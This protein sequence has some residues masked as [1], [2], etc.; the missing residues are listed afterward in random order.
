[1]SVHVPNLWLVH[2]YT[3]SHKTDVH[4]LYKEMDFYGFAERWVYPILSLDF[5]KFQ[6]LKDGTV[7]IKYLNEINGI[8]F[9]IEVGTKPKE[10][11]L[12]FQSRGSIDEK[13]VFI[14][15]ANEAYEK[16]LIQGIS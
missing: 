7:F 8:D 3:S 14:E 15:R 6:Y 4:E 16:Y 10:S 12:L 13:N 9:L 1:M 5:E 11:I 2:N